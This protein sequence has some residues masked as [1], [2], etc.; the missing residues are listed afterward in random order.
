MSC[1]QRRSQHGP[2]GL[3]GHQLRNELT[4]IVSARE[5]ESANE[6]ADL[7]FGFATQALKGGDRRQKPLDDRLPSLPR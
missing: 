4:R 5:S 6:T 2:A 7:R 1:E 3:S